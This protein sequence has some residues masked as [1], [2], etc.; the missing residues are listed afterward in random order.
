M[1]KSP[2]QVLQELASVVRAEAAEHADHECSTTVVGNLV[3]DI[4]DQAR[5][6]YVRAVRAGS[7]PAQVATD[8]YRQNYETFFGKKTVVGEA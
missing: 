2:E 1:K 7:G 4:C 3:A 8:A 6:N 5:E